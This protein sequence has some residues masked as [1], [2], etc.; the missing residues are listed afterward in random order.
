MPGAPNPHAVRW[1]KKMKAEK[2]QVDY[3]CDPVAARSLARGAKIVQTIVFFILCLS[4]VVSA[5]FGVAS[6]VGG[7][8]T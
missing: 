2:P 7:G 5:V 3:V 1:A 4:T 8:R 6:P